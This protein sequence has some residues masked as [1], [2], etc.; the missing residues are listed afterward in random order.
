MLNE[1]DCYQPLTKWMTLS[2]HCGFLSLSF[3]NCA[4][5]MTMADPPRRK[6]KGENVCGRSVKSKLNVLLFYYLK[7]P[8]SDNAMSCNSHTPGLVF[9][10]TE[11]LECPPFVHLFIHMWICP[12]FID[13]KCTGTVWRSGQTL[14]GFEDLEWPP[15]GL[16]PQGCTLPY[17]I[18]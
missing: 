14:A 9:Y 3:L 18:P 10:Q 16:D 8:S 1:L 4:V 6:G 15:V 11:R 17:C 12:T 5:R 2:D 7:F 13:R